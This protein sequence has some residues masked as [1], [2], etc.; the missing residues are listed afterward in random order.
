AG[1]VASPP[2]PDPGHCPTLPRMLRRLV[3]GLFLLLA[4]PAH[5][6]WKNVRQ[7]TL[8]TAQVLEQGE[9]TFG[10]VGLPVAY[11]LSSRLTLQTHP[12]LDLLLVHNLGGRYRL[13]E[14]SNAVLSVTGD[15]RQSFFS[16]TAVSAAQARRPDGRP[17]NVAKTSGFF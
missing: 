17:C 5:A 8:G 7:V 16:Q 2:L 4:A 6:D 10:V 14:T 11:G 1:I 15:V 13:M 12:I 3:I 9:L